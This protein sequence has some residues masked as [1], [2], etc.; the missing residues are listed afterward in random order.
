MTEEPIVEIKKISSKA[1]FLDKKH[2]MNASQIKTMFDNFDYHVSV[3]FIIY[4]EGRPSIYIE[5]GD[6]DFFN[7]MVNFSENNF[8][9]KYFSIIVLNHVENIMDI[10]FKQDFYKSFTYTCMIFMTK[11]SDQDIFLK[12]W[13][14]IEKLST[15]I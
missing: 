14:L 6:T 11:E 2:F 10:S 3:D 1:V 13:A 12:E 9:G 15:P 4:S 8:T 5:L 7:S